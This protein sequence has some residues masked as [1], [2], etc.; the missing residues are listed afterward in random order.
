V[1]VN[2]TD[3][4]VLMFWRLKMLQRGLIAALLIALSAMGFGVEKDSPSRRSLYLTGHY[5]EAMELYKQAED[6]DSASALG[7]ARCQAATGEYDE[8]TQT[9]TEAI[10]RDA[11][12]TALLSELALLEFHRGRD[13]M[14]RKHAEATI[15]LDKDSIT[16]R[17]T[18]AELDRTSGNISAEGYESLVSTYNRGSKVD[19]SE[20]VRLIGLAAAQ[21][22]RWNRNHNQFKRLVSEFYPSL[23]GRR[24]NSGRPIWK[25]LDCS[26]KNTTKRTRRRQWPRIGQSI[27]V[28]QSCMPLRQRLR[29]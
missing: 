7:L 23:L 4:A 14:A 21:V 8:A 15:A 25:W 5:A 1:L 18:L 27:P 2:A 3:G 16:A 11:R 22:A 6:K 12:S 10:G 20:E 17:W 9:L 28:R 13:E 19:T 26:Q 29:S 24:R